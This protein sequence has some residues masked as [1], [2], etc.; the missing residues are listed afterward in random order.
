MTFSLFHRINKMGRSIVFIL[1]LRGGSVCEDRFFFNLFVTLF[2]DFTFVPS[3]RNIRKTHPSQRNIHKNSKM[4]AKAWERVEQLRGVPKNSFLRLH[5]KR[6]NLLSKII[7][8]LKED[9]EGGLKQ[10]RK[11]QFSSAKVLS[12][13]DYTAIGE[14]IS[15]N[16]PKEAKVENHVFLRLTPEI[17]A[18]I[19]SL[20]EFVDQINFLV[21]YHEHCP[22]LATNDYGLFKSLFIPLSTKN[23]AWSVV[24]DVLPCLRFAEYVNFDT[25]LLLKTKQIIYAQNYPNLKGM[26]ME[27]N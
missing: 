27:M 24:F 13:A 11:F 10:L 23:L 25:D 21:A 8:R 15:D 18:K 2:M 9:L 4:P 3:Q 16:Q 12:I 7:K 5:P 26:K 19:L 22:K 14:I 6:W 1:F 17:W 20:V